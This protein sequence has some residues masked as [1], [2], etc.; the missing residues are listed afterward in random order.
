MSHSFQ[1]VNILNECLPFF[2]QKQ[3]LNKGLALVDLDGTIRTTKSGEQFI[4]NDFKD[5]QLIAGI[6]QLLQ[7]INYLGY[8]VIGVS[9]Q[10]GI[11]AQHK[12]LRS[13][14]R[15]MRYCLSFCSY[16]DRIYFAVENSEA[17]VVTRNS[18]F[19]DALPLSWS[20]F[21][22]YPI[23]GGIG[24]TPQNFYGGFRKPNSGMLKLAIADWV[25]RYDLR[26]EE[27]D[28]KD[29]LIRIMSITDEYQEFFKDLT[30]SEQLGLPIFM[31]GDRDEDEQAANEA[32][33]HFIPAQ[34]FQQ[35]CI[36]A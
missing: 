12:T 23:Y 14:V 6:D 19:L 3:E 18:P 27:I 5:Q 11:L 22:R 26:L 24:D 34:K 35:G 30:L 15:E 21:S 25:N 29:W 1:E 17:W 4:N 28:S 32:G 36:L 2:R 16:L 20:T 33:I 13:T 31:T 10:G 7:T 9:N 8:T